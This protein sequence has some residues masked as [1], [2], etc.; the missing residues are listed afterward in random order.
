M[1]VDREAVPA[2]AFVPAGDHTS[3]AEG[4]VTKASLELKVSGVTNHASHPGGRA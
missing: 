4:K 1:C 3:K 2:E